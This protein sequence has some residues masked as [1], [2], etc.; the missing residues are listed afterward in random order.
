MDYRKIRIP[1]LNNSEIRKRA[2]S[3]RSKFWDKSVP[4]NIEEIVDLKLKINLVPIPGLQRLC[5]TDALIT[6]NWRLIYIDKDRYIDER[7]QNRLRF[8][9]AH[10]I[11]H[12]VLHKNIYNSFKIKTFED[13]YRLIDQIPQEQ[14]NYLESQANKFANYLLVARDRLIIAK[15]KVLKVMKDKSVPIERMD[16][17]T[18]NSYISIPISKIFGVSEDVIQIAL[19]DLDK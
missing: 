12:F 10:E 2:D 6:S 7:F 8:S 19:S 16:K 3:F 1:F 18:I 4:V 17:S 15:N 9:L 13:F 14:Y 11:G 5:D